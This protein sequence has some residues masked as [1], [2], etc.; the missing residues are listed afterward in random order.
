LGNEIYAVDAS[1]PPVW[2]TVKM[3]QEGMKGDSVPSDT[4]NAVKKYQK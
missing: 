2:G 3:Q 4:A 1:S